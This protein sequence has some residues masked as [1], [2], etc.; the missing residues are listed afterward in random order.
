MYQLLVLATVNAYLFSIRPK[1]G[2]GFI[3]YQDNIVI[4]VGYWPVVLGS[5]ILITL[6]FL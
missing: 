3:L 1:H 2:C 6:G 5:L 4:K